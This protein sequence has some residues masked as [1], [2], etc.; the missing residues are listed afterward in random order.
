MGFRKAKETRNVDW[1]DYQKCCRC[2][3][4]KTLDCFPLSRWIP[5]TVCR[6]CKKIY[7]K[8]YREANKEKIAQRQKAY[9]EEHRGELNEK[10][11][12]NYRENREERIAKVSEYRRQK[13]KQNWFAREWFH[14]KAREYVAKHGI[15]F[16][17]CALC[18]KE[19]KV[20][21]HHPSYESN[22]MREYIVPLCRTCHR[23]VEKHPDKCPK[24]VKLTAL[25][26]SWLVQS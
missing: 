19:W 5:H 20:E 11:R 2:W 8:A 10:T 15:I 14:R 22:D 26:I 16:N 17:N 24:P 21:L 7:D 25:N 18:G 23:G 3:E 12:N 1:V 6:E 4:F 13:T 9:I